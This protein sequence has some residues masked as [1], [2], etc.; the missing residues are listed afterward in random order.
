MSTRFF[1][2]PLAI[3]AIEHRRRRRRRCV[4]A[5]CRWCCCRCDWRRAS[6][7]SPT[8]APS[9]ACASSPTRFTSTATSPISRPTSR[10]GASTTGSRTG[11]PAATRGRAADAWRQLADRFGAR[12]RR[13]DRARAAADQRGAT[14][15]VA[16][17]GGTPAH[18]APVFPAV[19]VAPQRRGVAPRRRR[20]ACC[21]TAGSPS[22]TPAAAWR[23]PSP[24]ATS[25][26]RSPSAPIRR[27]R[28]P[29]AQTEA[30]I[31]RGE[32]LAI[33]A[34]MKWMIDFDE[35]EAAGMAL[36]IPIPAAT[37]TAGLDS[38]VVFGVARSLERR[39]DRDAA[40]RPA[41]R[42]SLHRRPR[43]P[44][45][46]HADQQHRRSARRLQLRRS[47]APA[48]LRHR[49]RRH[50]GARRQQR[51][52][53]RHGARPAVR[54]DPADV[55]PRRA[56]PRARRPSHAQHEHR[57]VAGRLGLLPQQH[58]R[59]GSRPDAGRPRLGA[60]PLPRPRAQLRTAAGAALRRA[61]LRHPA[62]DLA[63]P[64]AARRRRAGHG[65]GRAGSR[66]C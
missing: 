53:R 41:R 48:Q 11:A 28:A 18:R 66:A 20:R 42:A 7:R 44:A 62:G 26:G 64:V 59:R 65:A 27:R 45:P 36:R 37:L 21:P 55:R 25:G 34:G 2:S 5:T 1:K 19:T 57:A 56:R 29:D 30:A 22:C 3:P 17:A 8:A 38:L 47:R 63:R 12:A 50:A 6:S 15:D 31:A 16:D 33:D 14:P 4:P 46:R 60:P 32:Q 39:R 51:A 61:A 49:G 13:L 54:P 35:A 52:A 43:V 9:C 10:R 40:R 58:D 23:S 24:A